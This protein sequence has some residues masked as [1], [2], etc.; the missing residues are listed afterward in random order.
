MKVLKGGVT[1]PKGFKANGFWAGVKK[2]GKPDLGLIYATVP[3]S[4]AAV[5]TRNSVKAAPILVCQKNIKGGKAQALIA[6]SGNANCFT[7]EY[8]LT[9]A[10][11]MTELVA[12]QF[13]IVSERVLIMSTGMIGRPFPYEKFS[14]AVPKLVKGLSATKG[15]SFAKAIM[16]TDLK[17]KQIAVRIELG[18]KTVTVGGC[19]K[20]SGMI[21]P[22]M[23]TMLA[24][25]T[26][27]AAVSPAMLKAALLEAV[28][29]SFNSITVDGCMS[30]NDMLSVMASGLAGNKMIAAKN[31][32]YR[33]FTDALKAVCIKLAK[34]IVYDGEGAE[35][36]FEITISGAATPKQ[37][38]EVAMKVANSNLVKTADYIDNPN[39]G[40]VAAAIGACGTKASEDTIKI[41]FSVK[42]NNVFIKADIGLGQASATVY[43]CDLTHGYIDING[44]YN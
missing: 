21:E 9:Y 29:V 6:N 17:D 31:A 36:F 3:C 15:A 19:A 27:D 39:W 43:S 34:D 42:R 10:L 20:G 16:T 22:N 1:T 41:S 30:T 26:T 4:A 28:D 13:G 23:A 44:R 5:F 18:G 35:R 25:V 33:I 11:K 40:R 8:G 32:D 24:C 37:A 7:G 2:S 12:S 14:E 38:K